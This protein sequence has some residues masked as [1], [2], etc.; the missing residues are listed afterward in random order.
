MQ[1]LFDPASSLVTNTQNSPKSNAQGLPMAPQYMQH[2][3]SK[4]TAYPSANSTK[5]HN[6]DLP[7]SE[8]QTPTPGGQQSPMD[9]DIHLGGLNE[10]NSRTSQLF[11]ERFGQ[12]LWEAQAGNLHNLG[13]GS[14]AS[15]HS[16][17]KTSLLKPCLQISQIPKHL[18]HLKPD[19]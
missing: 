15:P 18:E 19:H 14:T 4:T 8:R 3:L 13:T 17:S 12:Q 1:L 9:L 10:I 6:V 5:R 2:Q 11:M 16:R 7:E